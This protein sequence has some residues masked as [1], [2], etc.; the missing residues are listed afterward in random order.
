MDVS[1]LS[2]RG[3]KALHDKIRECLAAD[4]A[5]PPGQ[6]KLYCVRD[7]ADWKMQADEFEAE[8]DHRGEK[9]TKIQW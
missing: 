2:L 7:T 9:Y 1:K 5:T 6:T 3:L 8:L 4:D